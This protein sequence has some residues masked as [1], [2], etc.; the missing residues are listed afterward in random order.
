MDPNYIASPIR[1]ENMHR[2]GQITGSDESVYFFHLAL[3][4]FFFASY[5]FSIVYFLYGFKYIKVKKLLELTQGMDLVGTDIIK[6]H[7][8]RDGILGLGQDMDEAKRLYPL[9]SPSPSR[10]PIFTKI[11]VVG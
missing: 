2:D 3:H 5:F 1:H 11:Y 9:P 8:Y 7:A 4:F 10:I 6:A